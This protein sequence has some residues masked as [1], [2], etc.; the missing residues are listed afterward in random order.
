LCNKKLLFNL[1]FRSVSETVETFAA[2]KGGRIGFI[3]ILHTWTQT[4]MDHFHLHCV[5]PG[6][7]ISLDG[8]RWIPFRKNYL[9]SVKA[10][11][12][13]FRGKF[14][15]YLQQAFRDGQLRFPGKTAGFGT[16]DGFGRLINRLWKKDWVVYSKRPFAGPEQALDYLGRYTHRVAI[17]NHRIVDV[18]DGKVSFRYRDRK[19]GNQ[20]KIMTLEAQEFI[21]RFLLHVLPDGFMRIRHFG[22]LA[23]RYKKKNL[24]RCRQLLNLSPKRHELSKK[25]TRELMLELTGIDLDRCPRC[26]KGTMRVIAKWDRLPHILAKGYQPQPQILDSS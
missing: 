14:I 12:K 25:T 5:I 7:M 22:L 23:N 1:L 18:K 15:D 2:G 9:F 17:S 13:M 6:G 16:Q 10:L 4:L 24:S 8:R 11:S 26:G 3:A 20:V 21:R 19:N